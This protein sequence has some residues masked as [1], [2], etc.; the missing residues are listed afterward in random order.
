MWLEGQFIPKKDT[1]EDSNEECSPKLE[2]VEDSPPEKDISLE[3]CNITQSE[4]SDDEETSDS[5][6][7]DSSDV[8][9]RYFFKRNSIVY[10]FYH[11]QKPCTPS[12]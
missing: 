5:M 8:V 4:L 12:I 1:E 2:I 3:D 11:F 6:E 9:I 10:A 7:F